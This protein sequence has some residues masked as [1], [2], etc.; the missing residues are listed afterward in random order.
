MIRG[1][2]AELGYPGLPEKAALVRSIFDDG[3]LLLAE[4]LDDPRLGAATMAAA[5]FAEV[6]GWFAG[7]ARGKPARGTTAKPHAT[8]RRCRQLLED[9]TTRVQRAERHGGMLLTHAVVPA[10]PELINRWCSGDD[11]A[12]LC[13]DY[14]LLEGDVAT[15]VERT[16]QM[17]RQIAR[18]TA[19]LAA[20]ADINAVAIRADQSLAARGSVGDEEQLQ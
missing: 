11:M 6:V 12:A 4:L 17:L 13:R 9:V 10:Y 14:R 19:P 15:H 16:R 7:A 3:A 20:Y 8:L 1:T 2:L 18:A 5:D